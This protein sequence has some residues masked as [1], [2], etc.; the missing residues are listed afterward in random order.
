M[1]AVAALLGVICLGFVMEPVHARRVATADVLVD[2]WRARLPLIALA[3][4][5]TGVL[6]GWLTSVRPVPTAIAFALPTMVYA[7]FAWTFYGWLSSLAVEPSPA[8]ELHATVLPVLALVTAFPVVAFV[9][10]TLGVM[11]GRTL[12]RAGASKARAVIHEDA[13]D[14]YRK[15][16]RA[17][18]TAVI[19]WIVLNTA[20]LPMN[21]RVAQILLFCTTA[22]L[23]SAIVWYHG[24]RCPRCSGLYFAA[25]R[26]SNPFTHQCLHCGLRKWESSGPR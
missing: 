23:V 22:A 9:C 25:Y 15:R 26:R 8:A 10:C 17:A 11:A 19:A 3:G 2:A 5:A 24:W 7:V 4:A 6:G 13:W 18:R 14:D 16:S 12:Q 20:A 21:A 1:T